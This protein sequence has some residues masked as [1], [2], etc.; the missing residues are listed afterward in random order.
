MLFFLA[1]P[2]KT[3]YHTRMPKNSPRKSTP[4]HTKNAASPVATL[5]HNLHMT[6]A[7][8]AACMG[9]S[10]E[11][12][13]RWERGILTPSGTAEKLMAIYALHPELTNL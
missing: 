6:Q 10:L 1:K 13:S 9:V 11:A 8:F 5:R 4:K 2:L 3:R 12:V 7:Q